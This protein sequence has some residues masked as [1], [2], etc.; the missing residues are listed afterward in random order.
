M[1]ANTGL[2]IGR[3]SKARRI[4]DAIRNLGGGAREARQFSDNEWI[5]AAKLSAQQTGRGYPK[6]GE[7]W[8]VS[9]VTRALV[10]ET[11]SQPEAPEVPECP[12]RDEDCPA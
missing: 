6:R 2:D 3:R 8:H 1:S 12:A 11:L 10:I 9:D 4:A 7:Q 5:M